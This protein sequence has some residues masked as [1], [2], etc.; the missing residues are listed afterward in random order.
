M[1]ELF[2]EKVK[3]ECSAFPFCFPAETHLYLMVPRLIIKRLMFGVYF[4]AA[5]NVCN[6]GIFNQRPNNDTQV[7]SFFAYIRKMTSSEGYVTC[8][9]VSRMATEPL[10]WITLIRCFYFTGVRLL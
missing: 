1:F 7:F 10:L 6:L 3:T 4:K 5:G 8:I 9:L 2:A